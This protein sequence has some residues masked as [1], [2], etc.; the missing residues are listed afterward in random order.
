VNGRPITTQRRNSAGTQIGRINR[1]YDPHGRMATLTDDRNGTSTWQYYTTNDLVRA[2]ITPPS[3]TGDPSRTTLNEYDVVGRVNRVTHPDGNVVHTSYTLRGEVFATW[4]ARTYPVE[5]TYDPQGRM[6]SLKTWQNHGAGTG[7][8]VTQW[9]YDPRRGWLISK[10]YQGR[11]LALEYEYTPGGRLKLRR[12]ERQEA[13]G[14]NR[15]TTTYRNGIPAEGPLAHGDLERIEYGP[16]VVGT[17]EVRYTYDRA[18]RRAVAAQWNGGSEVRRVA[19]TPDVTGAYGTET[20]VEGGVNQFTLNRSPDVFF[21]PQTLQLQRSA[22]NILSMS[23]T[24]DTA[25]RLTGV[26]D[27]TLSATYSY[28]ANSDLIGTLLLKNG[29]TSRLTT[30]RVYD[31]WNRLQSQWSAANATALQPVVGS[32]Y[33]YDT[34]GQRIRQDLGDGSHWTYAYDQLGQLKSALRRWPDGTLV[35]GQQYGYQYDDIGNRQQ[36]QE[37]GDVNGSGLQTTTYTANL[38][39]QYTAIGTPAVA[40]VNGLA[41]R[42]NTV[43][44]NSAAT[45][46]Q[47]EYWWK[48]TTVNNASTPVWASLNVAASNGGSTNSTVNRYVHKASEVPSH[49]EDGN[50]TGDGRWHYRWDAENRLV[51]METTTAATTDGAPYGKVRWTYDPLGRRI[52]RQSWQGANPVVVTK[53]V[54][55]GWQ[56]IAELDGSNVVTATYAWGKDLSGSVTGAGGVGG[57]LWVHH[58]QHGRHFYAYDGNGNI[59]GLTSATDGTRSGG[60]EYDPFGGVIRVDAV[61][62]VVSWNEWQFST[63]RKDPVAEVVLYEYRGYDVRTGR[64]LSRDPVFEN[65]GPLLYG[66]LGNH[67]VNTVDPIGFWEL[68]IHTELTEAALRDLKCSFRCC[69]EGFR[70]GLIEGVYK[71]DL[72]KGYAGLA[73]AFLAS[74]MPGVFPEI[75]AGSAYQTHWGELQYLHSMHS[76]E[77]TPEQIRESMLNWMALAMSKYRD[78]VGLDCKG[79]GLAMGLALHTIQDSYSRSHTVR[80]PEDMSIVRFQ[81]YTQQKGSAHKVADKESGSAE[82]LKAKSAS[83]TLLNM[84][85]CD[86]AS[87]EDVSTWLKSD[88]WNLH[89][90][91]I[92]GGSDPAF[93]K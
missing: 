88:V 25:S 4:G 74:K 89:R 34:A 69:G 7:A 46:R 82:Y 72:P 85:V 76:V 87:D 84:M 12:W 21:R 70:D 28:Q 56:C 33:T 17:P 44:V 51:E 83:L 23:Y 78:R 41:N 24:Y 91:A 19:W 40:S 32:G 47:G 14:T 66:L 71:V 30:T 86:N 93:K 11:P 6:K 9:N 16:T 73:D 13:G 62:P 92:A 67:A 77:M 43:T 36:S 2:L 55:D 79:A 68:S 5:H 80:R 15:L 90:D 26:S 54:Y 35:A 63:K 10:Q 57:L 58:S 37:G 27:G 53:Y 52:Q 60:Y 49:D 64:W 8:A 3:G 45:V 22:T 48:E 59:C 20:V 31:R 65:G 61:N 75:E 18:G 42:T 39:N 29:A 50:Q 38:L 1:A 81:N